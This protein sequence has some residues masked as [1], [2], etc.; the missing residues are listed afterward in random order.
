MYVIQTSHSDKGDTVTKP[1]DFDEARDLY[2]SITG[3]NVSGIKDGEEHSDGFITLRE[4]T[5]PEL[6]YAEDGKLM[7]DNVISTYSPE[8]LQIAYDR[9]VREF[10]G[11]TLDDPDDHSDF[12]E[13]F[14]AE[15]A[16]QLK[17]LVAKDL[18]DYFEKQEIIKTT[19][20]NE[21]GEIE[22]EVTDKGKK[23][24]DQS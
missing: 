20:V 19:G 17:H 15:L 2:G 4:A 11:L 1:M 18:M 6:C 10:G 16:R 7:V 3:V 5:L 24:L 8:R 12:G 23:I 13:A 21:E 14:G 9:T 22:I